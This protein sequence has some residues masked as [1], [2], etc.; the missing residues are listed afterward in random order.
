M[1][2]FWKVRG[3]FL[4]LF[5]FDSFCDGKYMDDQFFSTISFA[6]LQIAIVQTMHDLAL[7]LLFY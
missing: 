7:Y 3:A 4:L 1:S 2:L 5:V 6:E